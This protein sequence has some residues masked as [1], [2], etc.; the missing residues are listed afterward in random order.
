MDVYLGGLDITMVVVMTDDASFLM[1]THNT[2][3]ERDKSKRGHING[4]TIILD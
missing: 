2:I 3:R 1:W 4:K